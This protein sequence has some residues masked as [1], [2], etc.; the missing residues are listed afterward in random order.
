MVQIRVTK[1]FSLDLKLN[2]LP[3]PQSVVS[4][5]DDWVI[6]KVLLNR[7]KIAMATHIESR[8]TFFF[9][10]VLVGGA[11]SVA[12]FIGVEIEDFISKNGLKK[13]HKELSS[14]FENIEYC[15][16]TADKSLIANMT[17]LKK[18]FLCYTQDRIFEEINWHEIND[19]INEI[20]ISSKSSNKKYVSPKERMLNLCKN[21]VTVNFS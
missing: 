6:D 5:F 9:P 13:Y 12:G 7:K 14:L 19:K 11:K 3:K 17:D 21:I 10:Y 16:N 18:V 20:I 1:I 2:N 4:I 8:L 15:V